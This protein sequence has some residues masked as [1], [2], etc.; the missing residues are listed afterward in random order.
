MSTGFCFVLAMTSEDCMFNYDQVNEMSQK[1]GD[2]KTIFS[3]AIRLGLD[4]LS[5]KTLEEFFLSS[6]RVSTVLYLA[7]TAF[8]DTRGNCS[9]KDIWEEIHNRLK[10]IKEKEETSLGYFLGY[11]N[12]WKE[13]ACKDSHDHRIREK[14][15]CQW[16]LYTD[17][18]CITNEMILYIG[19]I[20]EENNYPPLDIASDL[21]IN[22]Y[23]RI[24]DQ[25]YPCHETDEEQGIVDRYDWRKRLEVLF[26][27]REKYDIDGKAFYEDL[28]N[29][30][31]IPSLDDLRM[32]NI[33][34][35]KIRIRKIN[36]KFREISKW[37][38]LMKIPTARYN[39]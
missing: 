15:F 26:K 30:C 20:Y 11:C 38:K 29:G 24:I 37:E 1:F 8:I 9:D 21:G 7:F 10:D 3:V 22:S 6:D 31:A 16:E 25:K 17:D 12:E 28:K 23:F 13:K 36:N 33:P 14:N 5:I 34:E 35:K 2:P 18:F 27:G 19:E 39:N 32:K 4:F